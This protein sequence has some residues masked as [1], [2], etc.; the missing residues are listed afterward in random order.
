MQVDKRSPPLLRDG[1]HRTFDGGVA[2]ATGSAEHVAHQAVSV[3]AHQD[4]RWTVFDLASDQRHL[5]LAAIHLALIRNQAKLTI[6]GFY[7]RLADPAYVALVGHSVANQ[8]GH[9]EHFHLVHAAELDE[10]GNARHRAI[11]LH[12]FADDSC[13]DEAGKAGEVNG[14]FRL[15]GAYQNTALAGAQR[16]D[17]PRP[18]QIGRA[19]RWI[20]GY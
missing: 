17:V 12:D 15:P 3:H 14:S 20:N 19:R 5:G 10:V 1:T 4:R 2:I 8:L 6:Q 18:R 11:V 16:E 13:R 9:G 7:Q